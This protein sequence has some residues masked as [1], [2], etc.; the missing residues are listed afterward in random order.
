VCPVASAKVKG[1][2]R[3]KGAHFTD[4]E[5]EAMSDRAGWAWVYERF[6]PETKR[7]QDKRPQI[8]FTG[9]TITERAALEARAGE[10]F[11]VVH[12]VTAKLGYLVTGADPG[13][14]KIAKANA[15]NVPVMSLD[16]FN[17]LWTT[18]ALPDK[19]EK[20]A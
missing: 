5:L 17:E 18:G 2:L 6:P 16:A 12:A 9:F 15:Q 14:A 3:S 4:E 1:I 7:A 19:S 10:K 13:P 11:N 20:P 8:C